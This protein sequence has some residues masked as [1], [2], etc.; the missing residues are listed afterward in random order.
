MLRKSNQQDSVRERMWVEEGLGVW[1]HFW[2]SIR[3]G[4]L[5]AIENIGQKGLEKERQ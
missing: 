3:I 5:Y 4:M 2:V 1:N